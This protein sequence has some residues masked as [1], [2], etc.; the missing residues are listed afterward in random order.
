MSIKIKCVKCDAENSLYL[1]DTS[2]DGLFRCWKCRQSYI[3]VIENDE[4]KYCKPLNDESS[5]K[6]LEL[7]F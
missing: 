1:I 6:Q 4:L 7:D 3:I 5:S 2:Y